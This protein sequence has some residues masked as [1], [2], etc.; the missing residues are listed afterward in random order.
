MNSLKQAMITKIPAVRT[1]GTSALHRPWPIAAQNLSG[2]MSA[3]G[4]S[5]P[6]VPSRSATRALRKDLQIRSSYKERNR[7]RHERELREGKE[8]I[9]R[10]IAERNRRAGWA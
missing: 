6:S 2:G 8:A 1:L 10:E 5:R 7:D 9:A 4:E 3:A